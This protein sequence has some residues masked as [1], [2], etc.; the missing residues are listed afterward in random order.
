MKQKMTIQKLR[1]QIV[2]HWVAL[3]CS[4]TTNMSLLA[5]ERLARLETTSSVGCQPVFHQSHEPI[6]ILDNRS[7]QS[8][9]CC[10]RALSFRSVLPKSMVFEPFWN[11][12]YIMS[13]L[14]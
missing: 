12:T 3:K 5:S 9:V 1:F 7:A 2:S 11:V 13:S 10:V 8:L 4:Y 14:N 6:C